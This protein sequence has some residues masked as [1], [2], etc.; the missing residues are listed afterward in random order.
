MWELTGV[1][2]QAIA[3]ELRRRSLRVTSE[4]PREDGVALESFDARV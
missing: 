1:N 3:D 4:G 2:I